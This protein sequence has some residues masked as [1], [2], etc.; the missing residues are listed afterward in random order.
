MGRM[1]YVKPKVKT[2]RHLPKYRD[3]AFL[4]RKIYNLTHIA[5]SEPAMI[6]SEDLRSNSAITKGPQF[7]LYEYTI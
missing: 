5:K 6:S 7:L 1:T 4:Y 3:D 2:K